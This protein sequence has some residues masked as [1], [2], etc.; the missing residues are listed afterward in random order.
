MDKKKVKELIEQ[1]EDRIMHY[2]R[3]GVKYDIQKIEKYLHEAQNELSKSDWVSVEDDLPPYGEEVLVISK[4][5]YKNVSY[6]RKIN[7]KA[8]DPNLIDKNDF[9]LNFNLFSDEITHWCRIDK[10]EE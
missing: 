5:G 7:K 4:K 1:I 8:I 10:L 2:E 3:T 6:R 9:I